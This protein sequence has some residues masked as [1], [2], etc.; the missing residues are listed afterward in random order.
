M[1]I[2]ER[3]AVD[4]FRTGSFPELQREVER[5]AGF[6]VALDVRWEYLGAPG[7]D[8]NYA[9]EATRLYFTPLIEALRRT[10]R[11]ALG[12]DAL[13]AGLRR[14]VITNEARRIDG[15][16]FTFADGVLTLDHMFTN[17]HAVDART[18]AI[19]RLLADGL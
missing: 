12:R 18:R 1:G 9:A 15:S 11:D 8:D 4:R 16:T 14:I 17:I 6:A 2:A 10:A 5:A 3:R 7:Y 13:A 19:E